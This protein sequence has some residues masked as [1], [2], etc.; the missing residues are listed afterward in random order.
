MTVSTTTGG[1]FEIEV[2]IQYSGDVFPA[3]ALDF[4]IVSAAAS[5]ISYGVVSSGQ[6]VS[7]SNVDNSGS[8]ISGIAVSNPPANRQTIL[9]KGYIALPVGGG[10]VTLHW[11][12]GTVT[13]VENVTLHANSYI[14]LTRNI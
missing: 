12:D 7:P 13:G 14:K 1:E 6:A 8:I 10:T 5:S 3:S 11:G 9:V 4:S 2:Y